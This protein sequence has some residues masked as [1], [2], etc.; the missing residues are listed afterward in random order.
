M[1]DKDNSASD[2]FLPTLRLCCTINIADIN[3]D[4]VLDLLAAD[5]TRKYSP[6]VR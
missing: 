4:G 5:T 2:T 1:S 3:N 6:I